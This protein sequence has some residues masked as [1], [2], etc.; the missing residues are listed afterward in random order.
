RQIKVPHPESYDGSPDVEKF[1]AWLLA[2]LRWILIYRYGGPDY[3]AYRVSLVGLYL[4]GKA[5]EWYN[6]EVAGIH[7]TKEH[8]T[9]EETIIGLFDRCVQSATVHLAMQRFEEV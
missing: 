7:R 3:D 4:T 2:L 8:W 1:D 9:F 6:D 5:V